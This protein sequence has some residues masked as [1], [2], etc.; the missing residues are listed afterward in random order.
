MFS[1][2]PLYMLLTP[3]RIKAEKHLEINR[4][5]IP[6]I[7]LCLSHLTLEGDSSI[8]YV[9]VGAGSQAIYRQRWNNTKCV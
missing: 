1:V 5:G 8:F 7:V 9:K 6:L 2:V 3:L 4:Q